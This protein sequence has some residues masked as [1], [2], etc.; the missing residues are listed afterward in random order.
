MF[1]Q[2]SKAIFRQPHVNM[3]KTDEWGELT[4]QILKDLMVVPPGPTKVY[5]VPHRVT[6]PIEEC[7]EG[8]G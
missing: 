7:M 2:D 8:A 3:A 5:T 6:P 1:E 4:F